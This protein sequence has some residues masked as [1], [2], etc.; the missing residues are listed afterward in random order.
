MIIIYER[1]STKGRPIRN[2]KLYNFDTKNPIN[3][4]EGNVA[5]ES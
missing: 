5:Q 1:V 3:K 2:N 4:P